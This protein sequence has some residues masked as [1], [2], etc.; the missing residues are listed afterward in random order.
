MNNALFLRLFNKCQLS[1]QTLQQRK[2]IALSKQA[3]CYNLI[4]FVLNNQR[5]NLTRDIHDYE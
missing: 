2:R 1:V 5:V 4:K 3:S